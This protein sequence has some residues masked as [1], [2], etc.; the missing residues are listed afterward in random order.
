MRHLATVRKT[1][2][3][4]IERL[5]KVGTA[6][7]AWAIAMRAMDGAVKRMRSKVHADTGQTKVSEFTFAMMT[8]INQ[9]NHGLHDHLLEY[10]IPFIIG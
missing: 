7:I 8:R 4:C 9:I 2:L 3:R 10:R 6:E 5:E 1:C